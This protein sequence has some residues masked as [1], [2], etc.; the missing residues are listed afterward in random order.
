MKRIGLI[1]SLA[2]CCGLQLQAHVYD[3]MLAEGKRWECDTWYGQTVEY[4]VCGD[5]VIDNVAYK[6]VFKSSQKDYGDSQFHYFGA[7]RD[8][9]RRTYIIYAEGS[10][11]SIALQSRC[12]PGTGEL[13]LYDFSLGGITRT[14]VEGGLMV[15]GMWADNILANGV[16]RRSIFFHS[17]NGQDSET[18]IDGYEIYEGIGLRYLEPFLPHRGAKNAEIISTRCY[19]DDELVF[20]SQT[21]ECTVALPS[22]DANG[23]G[24]TDVEDLATVIGI[25]I[26]K[27]VPESDWD[28]VSASAYRLPDI[29][30]VNLVVNCILGRSIEPIY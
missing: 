30:H 27:H 26:T 24:I 18:I 3:P 22:G 28:D 13:L 6:K 15:G 20:D 25:V 2:L 5:T 16:E 17:I 4:K 29:E 14:G 12:D 8:H 21:A 10:E 23:D 11:P 19:I 9:N 1:F 7:A